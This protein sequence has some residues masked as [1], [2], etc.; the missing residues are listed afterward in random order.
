MTLLDWLEDT[1]ARKLFA[2]GMLSQHGHFKCSIR[3]LVTYRHLRVDT[4]ATS[5]G[6]DRADCSSCASKPLLRASHKAY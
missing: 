3:P 4:H 1:L 2:C 5:M 6:D